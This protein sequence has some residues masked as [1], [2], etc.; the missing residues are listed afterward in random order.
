MIAPAPGST[1]TTST[2]TFTWTAGSGASYYYVW[3]GTTLGSH[4]LVEVGTATTSLTHL[5]ADYAVR[6]SMS[7]STR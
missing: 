5:R 1:L 3:I 7:A 6:R 2:P 4:N